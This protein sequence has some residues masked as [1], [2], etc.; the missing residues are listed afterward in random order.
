MI[1]LD[2]D[3]ISTPW[4]EETGHALDLFIGLSRR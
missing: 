2:N 4:L 1:V 3:T